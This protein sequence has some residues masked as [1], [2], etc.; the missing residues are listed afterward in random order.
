[1]SAQSS[2]TFKQA[3]QD[4]KF[5]GRLVESAVGAY[6]I[7]EI[8]GTSIELCYWREKNLEADFV[9]KKGNFLIAIEVKS[10][11][12]KAFKQS[13]LLLVGNSGIS[14]EKFL[15]TPIEHWFLK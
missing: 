15:T 11:L 1:M 6:L 4:K 10:S 3:K 8:R 14:I 7:N 12:K 2:K 9:L 5:W 13:R